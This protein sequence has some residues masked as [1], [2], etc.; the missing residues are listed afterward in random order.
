MNTLQIIKRTFLAAI[1]A[2]TIGAATFQPAVA[3][4]SSMDENPIE[5]PM[6]GDGQETHGGKG[7]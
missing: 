7:R 2:L 1:V 5:R 3:A 6:A 4:V